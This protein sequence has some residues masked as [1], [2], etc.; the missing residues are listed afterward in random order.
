MA[1]NNPVMVRGSAR[2]V[3]N[4][5][6]LDAMRTLYGSLDEELRADDGVALSPELPRAVIADLMLNN[7]AA[8]ADAYVKEM[9]EWAGYGV[10]TWSSV[11]S[12][13][14]SLGAFTALDRG[15]HMPIRLA[16][17]HAQGITSSSGG[18]EFYQHFGDTAGVG[19]DYLWLI[20]ISVVNAD[21]AYP[22]QATTINAPEAIKAREFS[23]ASAGEYR[24]RVLDS[25]VR[26]GQR[27]SGLHV[28]GDKTLD[29]VMDAI[30]EQSRARG[31]TLDQVRAMRHA[32]DHCLLNPRPE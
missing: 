17:S 13:L 24:R 15:G 14:Q 9:N 26:A 5:R 11:L 20:G 3:F 4:T 6:A 22:Q 1:P 12:A 10:T 29:D 8:L 19:T 31:M 28:A 18:V 25:A 27:V 32:A 23:R 21:G 7:Q 30:E 2:T 16:Y